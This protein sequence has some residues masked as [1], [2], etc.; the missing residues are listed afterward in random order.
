[1]PRGT[2]HNPTR[3][4]RAQVRALFANGLTTEQIGAYL[5][6]SGRA[7]KIHY[8]QEL[9]DGFDYTY[10]IV[11]GR[12][13]KMAM[14]GDKTCMIFWLKTKAGW[15]ETNRTEVTGPNGSPIDIRS[16]PTSQLL[17][18]LEATDPVAGEEQDLTGVE[19]EGGED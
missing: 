2:P 13:V 19:A 14:E 15:R 17:K 11:S 1:M 9:K 4:T 10:A 5:H 12:L 18:A 7:V 16:V 6:L 8:K 3:E